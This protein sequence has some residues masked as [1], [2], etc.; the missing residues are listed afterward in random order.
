MLNDEVKWLFFITKESY[1]SN[2]WYNTYKMKTFFINPGE[3]ATIFTNDFIM[4]VVFPSNN[5]LNSYNKLDKGLLYT[6]CLIF[7]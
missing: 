5:L 4:Q 7:A 6:I 1:L 3:L 2:K